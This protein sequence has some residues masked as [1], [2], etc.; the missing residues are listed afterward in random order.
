[1]APTAV[2]ARRPAALAAALLAIDLLVPVARPAAAQTVT[3]GYAPVC[4]GRACG[5]VRFGISNGTAEALV[6]NTLTLV[7]SSRVFAFA[8]VGGVTTFQGFDSL[9]PLA[10]T[11]TVTGGTS[12]F[13]DFLTGAGFPFEL[14]SGDGG[15]VEVDLVGA[16]ALREGAFR[17]AATFVGGGSA[18]GTVAVVPEPSTIVLFGVG[19]AGVAGGARRQ[20]RRQG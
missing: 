1:M 3:A 16:P 13:V 5:T 11:A 2:L 7:G 9:G 8:A 12:L 19:L 4:A 6:F 18:S 10:G 15:F 17:F 14:A 20:R